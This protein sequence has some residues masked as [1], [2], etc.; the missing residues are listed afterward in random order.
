M[1]PL[2]TFQVLKGL[3]SWSNTDLRHDV[4]WF[5]Q[6]RA[7]SMAY[8]KANDLKSLWKFLFS[9]VLFSLTTLELCFWY[10]FFLKIFP[11]AFQNSYF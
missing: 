10:A 8:Y 11:W 4:Q 2:R 9:K 5:I 7:S 3:L 1:T 6:W